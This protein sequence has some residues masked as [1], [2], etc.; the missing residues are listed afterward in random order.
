[1][2][3]RLAVAEAVRTGV[4][5]DGEMLLLEQRDAYFLEL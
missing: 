5:A 1:M 2:S 4:V 3:Y